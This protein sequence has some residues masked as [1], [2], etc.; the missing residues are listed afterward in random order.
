MKHGVLYMPLRS[1]GTFRLEARSKSGRLH[2]PAEI[3]RD[4]Q[5]PLHEGEVIIEIINEKL[6]ISQKN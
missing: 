3:V 1:T 4:S 5:F 2:I 6:V